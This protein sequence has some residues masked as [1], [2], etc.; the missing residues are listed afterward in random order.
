[1]DVVRRGEFAVTRPNVSLTVR[2][3]RRADAGACVKQSPTDPSCAWLHGGRSNATC[4]DAAGSALPP[5]PRRRCPHWGDTRVPRDRS[6]RE[7]AR[8]F[9]R[10]AMYY[11]RGGFTD[12]QGHYFGGGYH[13]DERLITCA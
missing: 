3:R 1:V 13:F 8:Y 10:V 6:W 11:T 12:E 7:L 4:A 5:A 9:A 2:P